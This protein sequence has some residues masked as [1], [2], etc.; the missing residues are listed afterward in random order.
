M[1]RIRLPYVYADTDRHGNV[2]FY[3]WRGRGTPKIRLPGQRGS[4]EF[5]AAY[6]A[7]LAG[8]ALPSAKPAA[9]VVRPATDSKSVRWLCQQY[10][11]HHT[12]TGLDVK[13]RRPRQSILAQICDLQF[14]ETGNRKVGDAPFAE[15]P[16]RVIRRIR[17]LKAETPEGANSWLKALK[18]LFKWAVEE[19]H[20]DN[21]PAKDVPK[22]KVDTEGHHTWTLDEVGQFE[23]RHPIGSKPRLALALLLY[24]GCRRADVVSFG[25]QLIK[26]GSLTYTQNKNRNTAPVTLTLPVLP[27]LQAVIDATP[28]GHLTFLVSRYN[29]PYGINGFGDRFREWATEAGIPHCTPH[30]LRKAGAVRCA[31]NGATPHE[32]MA[33]FG[34]KDIKQAE[35]YTR[36]VVQK[37]LAGGAMD[38]MASRGK[39]QTNVSH[40]PARSN[41]GGKEA[42]KKP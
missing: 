24:T 21:N 18:A 19:E 27:V 25:P 13:T 31:Q 5:M 7:C 17:D 3:Y 41:I 34:W 14:G 28:S 38:K 39:T 16:S 36:K 35:L 32:L 10:L 12:F 40:F 29:K 33:I 9:S 11:A 22:I 1:T 30:G 42:P 6:H 26:D 8:K 15:M 2:R 37:N 23:A 4:E 20:C